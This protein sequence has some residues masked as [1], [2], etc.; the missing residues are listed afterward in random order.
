MR[1]SI[2]CPAKINLHLEVLDKREDGY[3]NI[4]TVMQ[5]VSLFDKVSVSLDKVECGGVITVK[6]S[7][8]SVPQGEISYKNIAFKAAELYFDESGIDKDKYNVLIEIEKQIPVCAGLGGGS[9]DAAGVMILLD[10]MLG[11]YMGRDRI[12]EFAHKIGA[13]VPFCVLG[14]AYRGTG[15]G[16]VLERVTSLSTEI[17]VCIAKGSQ[18]QS[19]GKAY[20]MLDLASREKHS[21]DKLI[22][23]L[24]R[25]ELCAI[26]ASLYNAFRLVND[27]AAVNKALSV[28]RAHGS[29]GEELSGSGPS[30]FGIFYSIDEAEGA[31]DRLISLGYE[32]FVTSPIR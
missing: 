27:S 1:E 7:D 17:F 31:R 20:E 10:I 25:E 28:M 13:D 3:H 19:T 5:S 26:G 14:G 24:E 22:N 8:E 30:V 15:I 9:T 11:V 12:A 21:S 16:E 2:F 23:A 4:D 6:C 32:A 29:V 18:K